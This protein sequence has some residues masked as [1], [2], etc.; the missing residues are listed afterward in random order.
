MKYELSAYSGFWHHRVYCR[1]TALRVVV[2][3][4]FLFTM[5]VAKRYLA[6]LR[7]LGEGTIKAPGISFIFRSGSK[8]R[9]IVRVPARINAASSLALFHMENIHNL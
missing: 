1:E 9:E 4:V 8:L 7:S 6:L 3:S 5:K 2:R